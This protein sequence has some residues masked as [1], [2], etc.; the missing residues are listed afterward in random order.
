MTRFLLFALIW[1]LL[2][3]GQSDAWGMGVWLVL[4][5]ATLSMSLASPPGWSLIGMLGFIPFFARYSLIGGVDV[6]RRAFSRRM[7][8]QPAIIEYPL[9]LR[10]PQARLF[11][12]GVIS[13]LPGT[14]TAEVQDDKLW[15]HVLD[16][17]NDIHSE[18]EILERRV[19]SLFLH[20]QPIDKEQL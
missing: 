16:Q 5:A 17:G 14:L 8:L 19:A 15:I 2:T 4:I 11:M 7:A 9:T 10:L 20:E 18:L 3:E 13:L 1:W 6:A 12:V